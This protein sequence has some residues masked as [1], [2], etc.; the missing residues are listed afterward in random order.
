M[1]IDVLVALRLVMASFGEPVCDEPVHPLHTTLIEVSVD[2]SGALE[3]RLRGFIDDFAAAIAGKRDVSPAPHAAPT[4]AAADGYLSTRL[5]LSDSHG[6]QATLRVASVQ[7]EGDVVRVTLRAPG[8]HSLAG[9]RLTNTVLFER[10]DDQVNIVQ[11]QDGT[12]RQTLL[13]TPRDGRVPKPLA[14]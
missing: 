2:A 13:F 8:I 6:R 11:T 14:G 3:I 9:L 7:H 1:V 10:Y 5:V 12:R 4:A